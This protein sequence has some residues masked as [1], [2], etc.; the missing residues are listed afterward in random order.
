M[1]KI[2]LFKH[3]VKMLLARGTIDEAVFHDKVM[4]VEGF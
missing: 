3:E 2:R 4:R 1:V